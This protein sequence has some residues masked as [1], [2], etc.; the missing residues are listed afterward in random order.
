MRAEN[1]LFWRAA[2]NEN[3]P[4][5][6]N[7]PRGGQIQRMPLG[8]KKDAGAGVPGKKMPQACYCNF[9]N[10]AC[11]APKLGRSFGVGV[12]SL[13]CTIPCLSITKAARAEVSPTPASI[14][15]NTS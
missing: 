12:C 8:N 5:E 10:A 7:P 15:N 1:L 4:H 11:T 2:D 14:G 13:Y 9:A 6:N 3:N